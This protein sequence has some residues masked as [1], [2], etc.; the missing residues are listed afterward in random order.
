MLN[1]YEIEKPYPKSGS[2]EEQVKWMDAYLYILTSICIS[3]QYFSYLVEK[4]E[5]DDRNIVN[6]YRFYVNRILNRMGFILVN[7]E[8]LPS[9]NTL[10]NYYPMVMNSHDETSRLKKATYDNQVNI[11]TICIMHNRICSE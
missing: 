8:T 7:L 5:L 3:V 10:M 6:Y 2:S 1:R 11:F 9:W 4:K